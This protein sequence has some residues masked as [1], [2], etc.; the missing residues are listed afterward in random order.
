MGNSK[1]VGVIIGGS[2]L[3]GGTLLHYFKKNASG[4]VDIYA[5][6]SKKLSLR[7]PD[8]IHLYLDKWRPDFI[9]NTA[10][11]SLDSDPQLALEV[12]YLGGIHL[13]KKAMELGV[14]YIYVS[15]A[16]T[17]PLGENLAE[18]E[19]LELT[20]ELSNYAKSKL[21]T[22]LTLDHLHETQGLDY[23]IIR[24]AIV[25]GKHDHKIQGF[26]RMLFT[27]MSGAMPFLF[28][29]SGVMH[30][31]SNARKLPFFVHHVLNN[32]HEFS[33]KTINF[34]DRSPVELA[35]LVLTIKNYLELSRPR[36]VYIPRL[37]AGLGKKCV[38]GVIKGLA[39]I[40]VEARMP[41]ELMFL[42][43]CYQT[44]TLSSKQL[45][46]SSFKDPFPDE[47]IFTYL[48]EL[49]QYYLTRWEHLNL[50]S[51]YNK[52]FF[53]PNRR[54]EQFLNS[55]REYLDAICSGTEDPFTMAS[56]PCRK[57]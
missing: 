22:E 29:K 30:S 45:E 40:G 47:T 15:S 52:E 17:Q 9:I 32:R 50:V 57:E 26:H 37:I 16:A 11:A 5:P 27:I 13:A 2:G 31:Y 53:D 21:M 3:I 6:N 39:G 24:L 36:S 41:A 35:Q 12:N 25:Y 56:D 42:D 46:S 34:V 20:P 1:K 4:T 38:E 48:P 43:N 44:Q 14:P 18:S 51:E 7:E 55:P 49:I 10:I 54:A 23:S 33:G 8:D 19:L 28:T